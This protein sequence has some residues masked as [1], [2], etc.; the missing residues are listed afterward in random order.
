MNEETSSLLDQLYQRI[1][2]DSDP[3]EAEQSSEVDEQ[4]EMNECLKVMNKTDSSTEAV[5]DEEA[6]T[7]YKSTREHRALPVDAL[8]CNKDHG[9]IK[10]MCYNVLADYF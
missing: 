8:I 3:P 9:K 1:K 7:L 10:V 4:S 5:S 6:G 2:S